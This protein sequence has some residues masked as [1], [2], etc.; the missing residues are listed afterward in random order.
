MVRSAI[1]AFLLIAA[2]VLV[3]NTNAGIAGAREKVEV[4]SEELA[5][6]LKNQ[7][8]ILEKLATMD[9]KLDQ[10]KMRIRQ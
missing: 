9:R 8:L 4:D 5:L 2:I 7:D 10:L 6:I 3:L 1:I